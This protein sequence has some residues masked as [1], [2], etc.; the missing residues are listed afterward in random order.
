M[1]TGGNRGA[2][3]AQEA[4]KALSDTKDCAAGDR[5]DEGA[6]NPITGTE[7]GTGADAGTSGSLDTADGAA[8][9]SAGEVRSA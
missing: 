3:E 7:V 5:A 2:R 8:G 4:R 6:T 9:D 1:T